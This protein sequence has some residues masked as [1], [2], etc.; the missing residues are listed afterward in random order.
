MEPQNILKKLY[1]KIDK[2]FKITFIWTLIIGLFT[3]FFVLANVLNNHD[4]IRFTPFRAGADLPS[5]RWVLYLVNDKWH[6]IWGVY[7]LTFLNGILTIVLISVSACIIVN[8][9]DVK[10]MLSCVLIGG[11][12]ITFPSIVSLMF[13]SF[14][15]P[16]YGLA[17]CV[18]TLAVYLYKKYKYGFI[19]AILC[20]AFSMGIY[21]A[22]LPWTIALFVLLLLTK[23]I[24]EEWNLYRT[25]VNGIKSVGVILGGLLGYFAILNFFLWKDNVVLDTYQGINSMGRIEL[26]ELPGIIKKIIKN[27]AFL[28]K[29]NYFS[30]TT[31]KIV[32]DAVLIL[33]IGSLLFV[34]VYMITNKK[35]LSNIISVLMLGVFLMIAA[36]SIEIMCPGSD[37]YC[38]MV[39]GMAVLF[40]TPIVLN[41]LY[42]L[43]LSGVCAKL[44]CGGKWIV[45]L[46]SLPLIINFT[47]QANGNYMSGY[48]TT[49]QTVAYFETL[50][51]RI[52]SVDGYS[53]KYPVAFI[54]ENYEDDSFSNSWQN[55]P[56][57]YGGHTSILINRYSRDW[58][59]SNYL[60]YTYETVS[61]EMLQKLEVETKDM[62]SYPDSGSIAVIDG[63]VVVKRGQ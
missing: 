50:V 35:R 17:I 1:K 42:P 59:M 25:I 45:L 26:K 5:G 8:I 18:A 11:I 43:K 32:R 29:S 20:I 37:I 12:V 31:T 58:F 61:D 7:N 13:F 41:E 49:E 34:V 55:T 63:V 48:W 2:R 28:Y 24:G 15:A 53:D 40:F 27:C 54:G 19:P 44:K 39:Y 62:P 10:S 38:L 6:K 46:A 33:M 30:I 47:W 22:Y 51:T 3:H 9:Y 60:G 36:D 52:K 4:N 57:W 21:Q 16:Y 23:C 14:T 56:F